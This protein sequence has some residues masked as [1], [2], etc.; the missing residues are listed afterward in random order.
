MQN[1]KLSKFALYAYLCTSPL[2]SLHRSVCSSNT[3]VLS[4]HGK[5]RQKEYGRSGSK[6]AEKLRR[7]FIAGKRNHLVLTQSQSS[8]RQCRAFC[9]NREQQIPALW[10]LHAP[11]IKMAS[12]PCKRTSKM[13]GSALPDGVGSRA[14]GLGACEGL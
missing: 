9:L 13:G 4:V 10:M 11:F 8:C 14:P 7:I 5:L 3:A 12:L 1:G 6:L 2:K